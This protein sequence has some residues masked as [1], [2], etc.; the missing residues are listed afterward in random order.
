LFDARFDTSLVGALKELIIL[1]GSHGYLAIPKSSIRSVEVRS[2]MLGKRVMV[3]LAD[4]VS[5]LSTT[6][7]CR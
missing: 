1:E 2:G 4:G 6:A 3:T 5:T 7:C